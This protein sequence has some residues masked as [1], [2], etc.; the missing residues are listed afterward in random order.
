MHSFSDRQAWR[1][2]VCVYFV[3]VVVS[4]EGLSDVAGLDGSTGGLHS[5]RTALNK[6][7]TTWSPNTELQLWQSDLL[8]LHI[9]A[10]RNDKKNDP[11]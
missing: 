1:V 10:G 8:S 9:R 5:S 4:P 2:L 11:D 3:S 7:D 6:P